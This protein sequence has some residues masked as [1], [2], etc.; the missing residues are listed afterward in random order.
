M[1]DY[2][3]TYI[4][5]NYKNIYIALNYTNIYIALS[6]T[7]IYIVPNYWQIFISHYKCW[8]I[9]LTNCYLY[10][11]GTNLYIAPNYRL[12][13]MHVTNPLPDVG[14]FV[15]FPVHLDTIFLHRILCKTTPSYLYK[16]FIVYIYIY[17]YIHIYIYNI[18]HVYWRIVTLKDISNLL[19]HLYSSQ[20]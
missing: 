10:I 9:S 2:R 1:P 11:T 16:Y 17:I 15:Q 13:S 6:Y 4:V 18:Y 3:N 8:F 20:L 12:E 7:N 19:K 14:Q 5:L